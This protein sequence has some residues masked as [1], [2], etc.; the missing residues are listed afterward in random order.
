MPHSLERFPTKYGHFYRIGNHFRLL[1][2][3][4]KNYIIEWNLRKLP[5]GMENAVAFPYSK[6]ERAQIRLCFWRSAQSISGIRL[7]VSCFILTFCGYFM[8]S[9]QNNPDPGIPRLSETIPPGGFRSAVRCDMITPLVNTLTVKGK[10]LTIW[11]NSG[12]F[13]SKVQGESSVTYTF[14]SPV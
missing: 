3:L 14:Q 11:G 4:Q 2:T 5:G 10:H 9:P 6:G 1:S 8:K 13:F 12:A 7:S